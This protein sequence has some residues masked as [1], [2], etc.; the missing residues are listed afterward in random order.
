M[1]E[2]SSYSF[3]DL[4]AGI[5]GMRIPFDELGYSCLFSSEWNRPAQ[6]TYEANFGVSPAG[7]I[8]AIPSEAIPPH[9]VLLA[10]FPCQAFSIMGKMRGFEDT[11]GTLFF[12]VARI[13]AAHSPQACLLENVK[14]LR[15]HGK[16]RTF[17]TIL[18]TLQE[19]GYHTKHAV[20]NALD[21][22][23]PQ[24]RER[25]IIVGFRNKEAWRSFSFD[26]TSQHGSLKD[27]LEPAEK[28][29]AN[30]YASPTIRQKRSE[31]TEGKKKF[32]PSVWH[33]NKGGNVSILPY[34]CALRA[35]ASYSYLLVDGVRRFTPRELLRLQGFPES[36]RIV[37]SD[38]E[39]RRQTGNSVPIPMIRAVAQRLDSA[40]RKY[41]C[42][43]KAQIKRS[44][45]TPC[46]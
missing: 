5:G 39:I 17:S 2:N 36:F 11:R 21:F 46:Q 3:I 23:L 30:C 1:G 9:D 27:I 12:E 32:S 31:A 14:Q 28:I 6:L 16:G 18:E 20:L 4:F 43:E 15:T 25:T 19:L 35:N 44:R 45:E 33:E 29:P 22:G 41:P 24:K 13:L 42:N 8:T 10:G 7:D 40:I 34:S 37:V 26:F 38:T